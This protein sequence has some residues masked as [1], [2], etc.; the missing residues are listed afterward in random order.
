MLEDGGGV[1]CQTVLFAAAVT[2]ICWLFSIPRTFSA[3]SG[4]SIF[5]SVCTLLSVILVMAFSIAQVYAGRLEG[6]A[7]MRADIGAVAGHRTVTAFPMD[8]TSF[9]AGMTAF[10][11]ISYT[12][13]G[14]ISLPTFIA[15]MRDPKY[16]RP[17]PTGPEL[18]G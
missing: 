1:P 8:E 3:L 15:E 13:I 16:A 12:F 2:V 7:P 4:L 9:A 5:T 6:L 11:N 14:Q 17:D 18:C 10:M